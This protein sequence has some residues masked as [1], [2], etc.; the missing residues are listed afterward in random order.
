MLEWAPTYKEI[1][2][3]QLLTYQIIH[4]SIAFLDIPLKLR[5]A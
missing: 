2:I 1:N 5:H 3:F 4:I